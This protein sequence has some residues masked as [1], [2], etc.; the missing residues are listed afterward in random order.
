M[1]A[2]VPVVAAVV[3][4]ALAGADRAAAQTA[5]ELFDVNTIQEIR[6]SINSRDLR[7]LR[8]RFAENTYYPADL[9]WRN[10]KVR[11]VG[12]RSR[13]LGS[14][15]ATKLGLRVDMARY[16]TGQ[17]FVGLST[18]VL[19]NLWQD[20]AMIR[21]RLAFTLFERVGLA[22]PRESFCRL[23]INNVYQGLY[24][25]VEPIDG[26]FAG[27]VFSDPGGYLY[28]YQYISP[29]YAEFLGDAFDAYRQRFQPETHEL[30]ADTTLF[31]PLRD[32]FKEINEP[33]DAV[34]RER[35]DARI[36]LA[37][38]MAQVAIEEFLGEND[39]LLG[40]A[41][42]NNFY[43]YR[44]ASSNRFRVIPWDRDFSFTFLE[45]SVLRSTSENVLVARALA[46]EDL[47][48]LFLDTL[49]AAAA[50]AA[51]DDWLLAQ[52]NR[53]AALIGAAMR[54]DARKQFSNDDFDASIEFLR[55]FA[56]E[57]PGRVFAEVASLR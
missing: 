2:R 49:D 12:V 25:M 40:Y 30:E 16:T 21:E 18:I 52:V 8:E 54:E 31:S 9:T 22:A 29:F 14:R 4:A 23:Y 34:W 13:G 47:R 42:M 17:T 20:D 56:V 26:T 11:N 5:A 24:A 48:T 51:A 33:D 32:L 28:E 3:F 53:Y 7:V 41:G 38:L 35:V 15:N 44:G 36:D 43:M 57:R 10:I 27:R 55:A 19:D 50:S 37:Q 46:R 6:L 1:T 45:S 39:A